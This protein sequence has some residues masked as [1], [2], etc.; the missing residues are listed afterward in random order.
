[1][2]QAVHLEATN[3]DNITVQ[4]DG[5]E[6]IGGENLGVRPMQLVLMAL[7]GCSSMD[8]LSILKKMKQQVDAYKVKVLGARDSETVPSVFT[9]IH[10]HFILKGNIEESK[11]AKAIKLSLEKYCSVAKMLEKTANIS[12][13]FELNP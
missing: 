11:A 3:E 7:G 1:M 10:V 5:S 8:V 12:Y 9:S 4:L 6:K 2:N 13:D